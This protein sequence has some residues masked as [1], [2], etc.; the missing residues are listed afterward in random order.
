MQIQTGLADHGVSTILL[1]LLSTVILIV[2]ADYAHMIY[3]HF[4]MVGL[5]S[6]K[7]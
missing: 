6:D 2:A 3:L 7:L 5:L 4:K 1:I